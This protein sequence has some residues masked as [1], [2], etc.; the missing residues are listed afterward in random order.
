MSL[1]IRSLPST[2][3]PTGPDAA[4]ARK[5]AGGITCEH[6]AVPDVQ[7]QAPR[8]PCRRSSSHSGCR[9]GFEDRFGG[10]N[11]RRGG[12]NPV[13]GTAVRA[14]RFRAAAGRMCRPGHGRRRT[15]WRNRALSAHS[16]AGAVGCAVASGAAGLRNNVQ[17]LGLSRLRRR[18]RSGGSG[19]PAAAALSGVRNYRRNPSSSRSMIVTL[20]CPPPSHMVCRP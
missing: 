1:P 2:G 14:A 15:L 10:H 8:S 17:S 6:A 18:C 7:E 12:W 4:G 11:R 20:A 3:H 13:C 5:V 9:T 19:R 16:L